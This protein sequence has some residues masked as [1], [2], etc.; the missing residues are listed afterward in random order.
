MDKRRILLAMVAA[1][2]GAFLAVARGTSDSAGEE[3]V[4][5]AE[6][7]LLYQRDNGGWPQRY[8]SIDY[9]R[10]ISDRETARIEGEKKLT[11]T[12]LDNGATHTQLQHL[13]RVAT[14]TEEER[15][16]AGFLRG[17]DY[18]LAA[19]MPCGG[20]AQS[21]PR[22]VYGGYAALITFND[23]AMIG[24]M[25]VLHN[26]AEKKTGS[27]RSCPTGRL[28]LSLWTTRTLRRNGGVSTTP[29]EI[30][31]TGRWVWTISRSIKQ[32]SW[33]LIIAAGISTA[34]GRCT[35]SLPRS[36]ASAGPATTGWGRTP[37][38]C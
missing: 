12:M 11:D 22:A 34:K 10:V 9:T 28:I 3:A 16:K 13:A 23:D 31:T 25:T 18:L 36:V 7:M 32:S 4:R 1:A 38:A 24:A 5:I 15:F 8:P 6:N 35:T 30:W 37:M 2:T 29:E 14:A 21:Y 33:T 20:W 26:V 19:Q 17:V 27:R